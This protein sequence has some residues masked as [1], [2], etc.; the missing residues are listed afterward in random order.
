MTPD[1][2]RVI[3]G[4]APDIDISGLGLARVAP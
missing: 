2:P 4:R 3:G 1:G